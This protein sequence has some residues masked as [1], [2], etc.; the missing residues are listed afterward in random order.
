MF[1]RKPDPLIEELRAQ[2]RFLREQNA[3][4][5]LRITE[6]ERHVIALSQPAAYH[7]IY[8][9]QEQEPDE[10]LPPPVLS[11]RRIPPFKIDDEKFWEQTERKFD[12]Q[13][14]EFQKA[15][16]IPTEDAQ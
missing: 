16:K 3:T 10:I 14:E 12:R 7:R 6:L 13:V 2:I 9:K 1:N 11:P 4:K 8:Q 15:M 5:D